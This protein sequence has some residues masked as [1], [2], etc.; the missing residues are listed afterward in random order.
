MKILIVMWIK[1]TKSYIEFINNFSNAIAVKIEVFNHNQERFYKKLLNKFDL[2]DAS[3]NFIKEE[4]YLGGDG[5]KI[6][7]NINKSLTVPKYTAKELSIINRYIDKN[8]LND[9]GYLDL[10]IKK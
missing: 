1:K 8:I 2:N 4:R 6:K 5:E 9:A 7:Y 3:N 10:D